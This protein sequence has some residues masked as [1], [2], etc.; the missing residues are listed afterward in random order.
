MSDPIPEPAVASP[1]GDYLARLDAARREQLALTRRQDRVALGRLA[2]FALALAALVGTLAAGWPAWWIAPPALAFL[3]LV[4]LSGRVVNDLE[5]VARAIAF[6]D[7]GL[8]R[9]DD[10]WAI[11]GSPSTPVCASASKTAT[12]R[13]SAEASSNSCGTV[14]ARPLRSSDWR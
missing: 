13:A 10:R 1:R 8:A 6:Y 14:P 7:R 3:A 9:L 12:C 5:R 11:P 4:F 2:T